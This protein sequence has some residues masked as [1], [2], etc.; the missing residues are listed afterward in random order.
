MLRLR[1]N[2]L[3]GAVARRHEREIALCS[4]MGLRLVGGIRELCS[5]HCITSSKQNYAM[6]QSFRCTSRL[7][8]AVRIRGVVVC[9]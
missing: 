8:C 3:I 7:L 5:A 1:V 6:S 2:R 9:K 4:A